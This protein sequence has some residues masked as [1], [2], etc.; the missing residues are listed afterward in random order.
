[1]PS[2]RRARLAP[3]ALLAPLAPL[4]LPTVLALAAGPRPL[5][6]QTA[7]QARAFWRDFDSQTMNGV[8]PEINKIYLPGVVNPTAEQLARAK[9]A[10]QTEV[11][12]GFQSFGSLAIANQTLEVHGMA[13][14]AARVAEIN[15][16]YGDL[17]FEG[18]TDRLSRLQLEIIKKHF[19]ANGGGIDYMKFQRAVEMFANGELRMGGGNGSRE[20]DQLHQWYVWQTFARVAIDNSVDKAAW[21]QL[22]HSLQKGTEIY[23]TVYPTPA[24]GYP[25]TDSDH[26]R[27][28]AG[29]QLNQ[30]QIIALRNQ[31]DALTVPQV[32]DRMLRT[33]KDDTPQMPA[34]GGG[35][36][37]AGAMLGLDPVQV[38]SAPGG[39]QVGLTAHLSDAAGAPIVGDP[40]QLLVSAVGI[41][42][43]QDL[44]GTVLDLVS[45]GN[46]AYTGSLFVPGAPLG[47]TFV[48]VD[49][50]TLASDA[51][52]VQGLSPVPEP[53]TLALLGTGVLGLLTLRRRRAWSIRLAA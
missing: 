45:V 34:G 39:Y 6:A 9:R 20:M 17:L 30:N 19:P 23:R 41:V 40:I 5:A 12:N 22:T 47:Y 28:N 37:G 42:V 11:F 10:A 3:L 49:D 26:N 46:G 2:V 25:L 48:A 53:A 8:G 18:V 7:A 43:P 35:G 29:K 33:L 44:F 32:F 21:E 1:M 51:V 24:G 52:S 4:A 31:V 36:G 50:E 14:P 13:V 15:S 16:F 38:A 27:F